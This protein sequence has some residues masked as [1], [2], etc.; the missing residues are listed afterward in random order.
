MDS[1]D[2]RG[3]EPEETSNRRLDEG[4][5]RNETSG[6]A[7]LTDPLHAL[8]IWYEAPETGPPTPGRLT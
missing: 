6:I 7:F 2:P 3:V 5:R 8:R 4:V 1:G